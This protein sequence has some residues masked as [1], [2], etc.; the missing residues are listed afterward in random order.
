VSGVEE[1][2]RRETSGVVEQVFDAL[3]GAVEGVARMVD[4]DSDAREVL[5]AVGT[6][7]EATE[8]AVG[9]VET[10]GDVVSELEEGDVAGAMGELAEGLGDATEAVGDVVGLVDGEAGELL[11]DVGGALRQ[12]LELLEGPIEEA[13]E[14]LGALDDAHEVE[15]T[16]KV[17]GERL[18]LG[19]RAVEMEE[20]LSSLASCTVQ[21]A[22]DGDAPPLAEEL[23]GQEAV[24]HVRRD[25]HERH[26][27]GIVRTARVHTVPETGPVVEVT[28][29]PGAWVLTQDVRSQVYQ[30][31]SVLEIVEQLVADT[32]ASSQRAVRV[33]CLEDYPRLEYCVQYRES[34]WDFLCRILEENG[35]FFFFD[36]DAEGAAKEQ[37]VLVD[38]AKGLVKVRSDGVVPYCRDPRGVEG[39]EAVSRAERR[40]QI[41]VRDVVV[42]GYDWTSPPLDVEGRGTDRGGTEAETYLH[43]DAVRFTDYTDTSGYASHDAARQA[44]IRAQ[45][46]DLELERW[47]LRTSVTTAA[48]G[49]LV[50]LDDCPR[51]DL[52]E[53]YL[54]VDATSRGLTDAGRRGRWEN[55]LRVVPTRL[56]FRPPRRTPKPAIPGPLTARVVG[57]EGEEIHTDAHGRVKVRFHWDRE[58]LDDGSS[59]CWVRVAQNMAGASWGFLFVP[60]VGMEVVVS[61][62]E[63]DPDRPLVT[64]TV[65]N[66]DNRAPIQLPEQK[67]QSVIRTHSTGETGGYN[68]LRFEDKAHEEQVVLRAERDYAAEVQHD[69]THAAGHDQSLSAGH[70]QSLS[71]GRDQSLSAERSQRID[72]GDDQRI[73]VGRDRVERVEGGRRRY[74]EKDESVGVM[75]NQTITVSSGTRTV[76]VTKGR[77]VLETRDSPLTLEHGGASKLLA[78]GPEGLSAV[79][80]TNLVVEGESVYV[81]GRSILLECGAS[82]ISLTPTSIS[83]SAPT[84]SV[85][86]AAPV[87]MVPGLHTPSVQPLAGTPM[88]GTPGGPDDGYGSEASEDPDGLD[89]GD[90]L[91][92]D[93][94]ELAAGS[95]RFQDS[96]REGWRV[97]DEV[98]G[99]AGLDMVLYQNRTD[100]T[101][102]VIAYAGT[103]PDTPGAS[104]PLSR[105]TAEDLAQLDGVSAQYALSERVTR[106]W[107]NR[108]GGADAEVVF[109]GHSLGGGLAAYNAMVF[110]RPAITFNAA[111]VST[112]TFIA[113]GHADVTVDSWDHIVNY[114]DPSDPISIAQSAVTGVPEALG[115]QR[116]V[117]L[118]GPDGEPIPSHHVEASHGAVGGSDEEGGQLSS[119]RRGIRAGGSR[120]RHDYAWSPLSA[121]FAEGMERVPVPG[122]AMLAKIA[123][124]TG[125]L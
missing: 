114:R 40:V 116:F 3:E 76:S 29:V 28:L 5:E 65:Y 77:M 30:D 74:V 124:G 48:P 44:R 71:A 109:T 14:A 7:L 13:L 68:E 108:L 103:E 85:T 61:F 34:R 72:V 55:D 50:I 59:S 46:L 1:G 36:H 16:L 31:L 80:D 112:A 23:I 101:R 110:D 90:H 105:D 60:R 32:L 62:I 86:S 35:I 39:Q 43:G 66:G 53:S 63:G 111:G 95:Y 52:N 21:A 107:L 99:P 15:L 18:G 12:G 104:L 57:P 54:I 4:E 70:D 81:S 113:N 118:V 97:L 9:A 37:L 102:F 56:P 88:P 84:V 117:E 78:L 91:A 41:G 49:R 27:R 11:R 83:I 75:G 125:V 106:D 10:I 96:N 20:A 47:D 67:T 82:S 122:V 89:P 26:F 24:L 92:I 51:S 120:E 94:S 98:H 22:V 58:G 93:M 79:S 123:D 45:G 6:V 8:E 64:G 38:S 115:R 17:E 121:T 33:E 100:P 19:V 69:E 73:T 25:A 87:T 42:R 2:E 119:F